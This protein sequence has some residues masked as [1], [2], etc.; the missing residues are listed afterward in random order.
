MYKFSTYTDLITTTVTHDTYVGVPLA[1]LSPKA[2]GDVLENIGRRYLEIRSGTLSSNA[3]VTANIRG[4]KRGRNRT[5]S[6]FVLE[7]KRTEVKSAQLTWNKSKKYWKAEFKHIKKDEY[8]ILYLVLYCPFG[9]YVYK[10][11][12]AFGIST[13]GKSQEA[14][15][16][17]VNVYGPCNLASI[18]EA[19]EVVKTKMGQNCSRLLLLKQAR[20][21]SRR[22]TD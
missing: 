14:E 17:S 8:D 4:V 20:L 5:R 22:S 9:V 1:N 13:N 12:G 16:G 21:L 6:D 15:G 2:R 7:K 10:H 18:E 19:T 11:D 3:K